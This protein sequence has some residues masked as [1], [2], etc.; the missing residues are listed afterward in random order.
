MDGSPVFPGKMKLDLRLCAD[1]R[2]GLVRLSVTDRIHERERPEAGRHARDVVP[3]FVAALDVG[4]F[5]GPKEGQRARVID[6]LAGIEGDLRVDDWELLTPPLDAE[7]FV[8]LARMFWTA[9]ARTVRIAEML[10]DEERAIRSVD[11]VPSSTVRIPPWRVERLVRDADRGAAVTVCFDRPVTP[12]I[13]C[14]TY[15]VLRLWG[16]LASLGAFTG[17]EASPSSAAV[18]HLLGEA[19][20]GE[21]FATFKTFTLGPDGWG[22]LWA[23]LLRIHRQ[24]PI[25]RVELE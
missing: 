18:L 10:R 8:A 6:A 1:R 21:V 22:S 2:G 4:F 23:G 12:E 20:R 13:V 11:Q 25:T 17:G 9:G 5:R 19:R 3:V 16:A 7:A 15:T 14:S 24:A